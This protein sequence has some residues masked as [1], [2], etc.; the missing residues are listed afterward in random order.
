MN[1]PAYPSYPAQMMQMPPYGFM[2]PAPQPQGSG[3]VS[4]VLLVIVLIAPVAAGITWAVLVEIRMNALQRTLDD[5]VKKD[6]AEL[7]AQMVEYRKSVDATRE[8]L[9]AT[10]GAMTKVAEAMTAAAPVTPAPAD[11]KPPK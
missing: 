1:Q 7:R 2:A 3:W 10:A 4:K 9:A 6:M 5:G 11:N 8:Q